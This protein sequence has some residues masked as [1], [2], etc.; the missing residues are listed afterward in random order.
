MF[1]KTQQSI[2]HF[3]WAFGNYPLFYNCLKKLT[4]RAMDSGKKKKIHFF[5]QQKISSSKA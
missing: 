1:R 2:Q 5:F 3:D 4:Q